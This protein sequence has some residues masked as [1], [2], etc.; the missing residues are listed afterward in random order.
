M[1]PAIVIGGG[2]NALVAA[3]ALAGRKI[4]SIVIERRP[5]AG[6]AAITT[7]VLQG[8]RIPR[9]SHSVGPLHRDVMRGLRLDRIPNLEFLIPDPALTTFGAGGETIAF[10]PDPVLT[11]AAIDRVSPKDAGRWR[12]FLRTTNRIAK[13]FADLSRHAPPSLT[14]AT[15]AEKLWLLRTGRR[16]RKLGRRDLSRAVR[17]MAMPMTDILDE[18]FES[19][20]LK[21]AIA[22]RAVFGH[23]AGPF[24]P[25]TGA[26]W[27]Q[28][29]ADDPAPAGSGGWV[30]GGPGSLSDGLVGLIER[31]G[32][33]VRAG[34]SVTSITVRQGK[35]AG[36]VLDS[37]EEIE[38][39]LAISGVDPR[40]T[41]LR[42]IQPDDLAPSF[43][44][45]IRR[46]RVRGVTAKINLALSGR[47]E[48]SAVS[49]DPMML[50][51]RILIA[52]G[53][54][55]LERAFDAAKYGAFSPEPWL[56]LF[57]PSEIDA[58]LAP[59]GQHVMSVYVHY[60]PRHLRNA[61]WATERDRLYR[62][63]MDV[64]ARHAPGLER[65]IID[66]EVLTPEDLEREWGLTGGHIFHGET[67]M[68]QSWIARP[69]L[70]CAHYKTPIDGLYLAGAGTHPGG[71][72]TGGSGWL[73][74]QAI[75]RSG[76][77]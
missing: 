2:L 21:A 37:G 14:D 70:G 46:Y 76:R 12:E 67:T 53:L 51:G 22:A 73:A 48:F 57:V 27:L 25:G 29:M 55:Y 20:L 66:G 52:P 8:F 77:L 64:L 72:L 3:A 18:W 43:I 50:R 6:G 7:E 13:L 16:G 44:E 11:A 24:S 49:G 75:V 4:P 60:A 26:L 33:Q 42:L 71:G 32:G 65:L 39:S 10:H 9:L 36:V 40:Q 63:A 17:W 1:T 74:A 68:D 38:G 5:T 61:E 31:G 41:F 45:R 30:R 47:P 28:R 15:F 23:L 59:E 58:S 54:E 35:V 56:E 34:T 62:A 69:V 19:D